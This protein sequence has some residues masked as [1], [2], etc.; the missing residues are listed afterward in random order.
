MNK[1]ST[2]RHGTRTKYWQR[3]YVQDENEIVELEYIEGD[4]LTARQ[5]GIKL[6]VR[7]M[8]VIRWFSMGLPFVYAGKSKYWRLQELRHQKG[9]KNTYKPNYRGRK[10]TTLCQ[11]IK[12]AENYEPKHDKA[13]KK[14]ARKLSKLRKRGM[15]YRV[16][17]DLMN[18]N[19]V[20]FDLNNNYEWDYSQVYIASRRTNFVSKWWHQTQLCLSKL[21]GV[22]ITLQAYNEDI[23]WELEE[24]EDE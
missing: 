17:S 22:P 18:K 7:S 16:I 8:A 10:K 6:G 20:L 15:K 23:S 12:W 11:F 14:L 19:R 9:L 1:K 3:R 24:V 2:D 13:V 4:L 5:L 21:Q